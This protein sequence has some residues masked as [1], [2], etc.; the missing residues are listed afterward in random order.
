MN[1]SLATRLKRL[2]THLKA[3]NP[4]LLD[5]IPTYY[6]ADKILRGMGLIDAQTSL[7]TRISWWPLI[8]VLGTFSSGKSTFINSFVGE[9]VQ[10]T[11]NQ[12]VD[13]KFTVI[14]HRSAEQAG[15]RTLPGTALD[16]DG[17]LTA[18]GGRVL[19]VVGIGDDLADARAA[20]Y[21]H[22]AKIDF[23]DGFCR[24]DI[25]AKAI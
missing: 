22:I 23:P 7:A 1:Q 11:G 6:K 19:V 2:E 4:V 18:N 25:A 10:D 14:C 21:D 5:V 24:S 13:D 12:A 17:R 16:A 15:N 3:E 8:A 20:V 9:K